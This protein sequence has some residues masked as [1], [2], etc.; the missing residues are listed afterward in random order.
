MHACSVASDFFAALW[1]VT[2]RLLFPWDFPGKSAGLGRHS[3]LQGIFLTQGSNSHLLPG[4]WILYC[5]AI[6]EARRIGQL[7]AVLLFLCSEISS[8]SLVPL[9][10]HSQ[11]GLQSALASGQVPA[12]SSSLPVV[13]TSSKQARLPLPQAWPL[14]A[15]P[16]VP[17]P[18][19]AHFTFFLHGFPCCLAGAWVEQAFPLPLVILVILSRF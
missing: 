4:E 2:T 11:S 13:S 8:D 15:R 7:P 1:I 18:I 6:W 16:K 14:L 9:R 19:C 17:P 12:A 10:V 3:F 5:C